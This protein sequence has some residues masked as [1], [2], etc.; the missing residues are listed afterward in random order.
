MLP[1]VF[2]S[3]GTGTPGQSSRR[4]YRVVAGLAL[5]FSVFTLLGTLLLDALHLPDDLVRWVGLA[6]L[7]L[8][9]I[10]M[11]V[12]AVE[13]VLEKPFSRVPQHSV[14]TDRGGFVLGLALG[15]VY[16][17]CAGPV[18]TAITVAGATGKIGAKTVALTLAF[19]AGTAIPLLVFALAGRGVVDRVRAFRQHQ[20]GI[21]VAAGVLLV[22]LAVAL[23][24]NVTD[25]IQRTIPDYTASLNKHLTGTKTVAKALA[26]APDEGPSTAL[27]DCVA[28]AQDL[29]VPTL[30]SCGPAPAFT[31]I[32]QWLNTPGDAPVT[33]ASLRG[34][35][36]LVDF[37]AYS[38]INCQRAIV[39]VTAWDKAYRAAGLEV[40]GVHT[41]EYAFEHVPS[42][43]AAGAKRL[44]IT[45]PVALDN[46]YDTWNAYAND[47]WPAD[48]LIDAT[49]TVRHVGIGEGGYADTETMIRQ[50]LADADGSVT[51]PDPT[52]LPDTTPTS[53]SQ[54]PETYLG[55]ARADSFV[56]TDGLTNG[57]QTFTAPPTVA[58]DGFAL[59]GPW[60]VS[61]ESVTAAGPNAV[62][63]L[64]FQADD[65]YLDVGGTGTL[66]VAV[67]GRTTTY[68][69][70]GA[71]NIYTVFHQ[72]SAVRHTIDVTLTAG[73]SAY[74]FT[75]G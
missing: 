42:D 41:P 38:C 57:T 45:Y 35:V 46:G 40:I 24:F 49:G 1:V 74:S 11:I 23:N 17:P 15:A 53:P 68:Q 67:D 18:L 27:S 25:R 28:Q 14:S 2:L 19:A 66:T 51:L 62:V 12:P 20:R 13:A 5:S 48:Y 29:A 64:N 6:V 63:G 52:G 59:S 36:V 72:A 54:T 39:H 75:F 37:W 60:T 73:L 71:P 34:K 33:L 21:R 58:L 65:V 16:V 32:Q 8:L 22:A 10:G 61:D 44:G 56:G 7:V 30:Q 50:L 47:S 55:S 70:T 43:V 31:G 9:G 69:V 4:P 3:S 26:A